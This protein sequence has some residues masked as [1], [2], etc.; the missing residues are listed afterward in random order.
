MRTIIF[1]LLLF[2]V[3]LPCIAQTSSVVL[4]WDAKPVGEAWTAVRCYEIS[5]TGAYVKVGEVSGDITQMT[6][7]GVTA[8]RHV[9]IVRSTDG[10]AESA[11]SNSV[12]TAPKSPVNLRIVIN[13]DVSATVNR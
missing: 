1:A 4:E 5:T 9:Y 2:L 13:V 8:G 12:A 11:D 7:S 3:T 10:K 6:I